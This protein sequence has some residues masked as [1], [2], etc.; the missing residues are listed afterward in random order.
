M[1]EYQEEA[2]R[3]NIAFLVNRTANDIESPYLEGWKGTY[4]GAQRMWYLTTQR[5]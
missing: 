1:A 4:H 2:K 3:I 5:D